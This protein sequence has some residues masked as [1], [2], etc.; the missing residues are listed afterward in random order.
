MDVSWDVSIETSMYRHVHVIQYVILGWKF[1][2]NVNKTLFTFLTG[3]LRKSPFGPIKSLFTYYHNKFLSQNIYPKY[4]PDNI[5]RF[6]VD[7]TLALWP[8][9]WDFRLLILKWKSSGI[10]MLFFTYT[11]IYS[12]K[13]TKFCKISTLLLTVCTLNQK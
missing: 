2:I 6:Y 10:I 5:K 1:I 11:F 9:V 7:M 4:H 3:K 12:E 13:A 8:N